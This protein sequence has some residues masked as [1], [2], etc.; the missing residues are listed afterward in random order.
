MG[1]RS[2]IPPCATAIA[3]I[4]CLALFGGGVAAAKPKKHRQYDFGE[5]ILKSGMRGK[6]VRVLQRY[7]TKLSILTPVDGAFGQ[8]TRK[9]VKR[10]ERGRGWP[11]DGKVTKKEARRIRGLLTRPAGVYFAYGLTRPGV[12]LTGQ[13]QGTATVEVADS[14]GV[15]VAAL[16]VTFNGAETQTIAWDALTSAGGYAADDTYTFRLGTTNTAGALISGGQVRPFAL[17][18]HAFPLPGIHSYGGAG[19]RF[20][21]SRG[22][23]AHQG[24]DLSAACGERILAAE[25]GTLRVNTYQASGAGYYV[26]VRGVVTGTDYVYMHMQVASPFAPGSIVYTGQQIGRVGNTGSSTGCHLHFEHWTYPG[27]FLGGYP[28]DP[29]YELKAWDAYS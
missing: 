8:T 26:V 12:S 20:G 29:F 1:R 13:R 19:S 9:S 27:W 24:Q 18:Q 4:V 17:R 11:I 14:A 6:D 2:R 22:T 5:R 16:S 21:A 28:Y 15:A 10:L 23:R 3:A 25:G 7:L